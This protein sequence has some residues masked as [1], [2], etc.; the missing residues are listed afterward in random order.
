MYAQRAEKHPNS[1]FA[2]NSNPLR[3]YENLIVKMGKYNDPSNMDE[4]IAKYSKIVDVYKEQ[5]SQ[6]R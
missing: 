3:L 5:N 2:K 6:L 4:R 1:D